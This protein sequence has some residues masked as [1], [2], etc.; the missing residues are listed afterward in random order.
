MIDIVLYILKYILYFVIAF[1]IYF[2]YYHVY[3]PYSQRQYYKKYPNIFFVGDHIPILGDIVFFAKD[4]NEGRCYYD[5]QRAAVERIQDN[6]DFWFEQEGA[7]I[8]LKAISPKAWQEMEQL[9]PAKVDRLPELIGFGKVLRNSFISER[10]T[11]HQMNRRK[12]FVNSL[13][14]NECSKYIPTMVKVAE[15]RMDSF[16]ETTEY[17]LTYEMYIYTFTVFT[18][19]IFG[20]DMLDLATKP[21]KYENKLG[22]IETKNL[23]E[24]FLCILKDHLE[25]MLHPI[26]SFFP[27][28]NKKNLINPFK[29]NEKNLQYHREALKEVISKVKDEKSVYKVLLK[30]ST[31]SEEE[32]FGDVAAILVAGADT[33]SHTLAAC[34]Y[35][36]KK[37]PETLEKLRKELK[38]RGIV[39]D[40]DLSSVLTSEVISE[41]DYLSY[42]I[43][44]ALR[45]DPPARETLLYK[46]YEDVEI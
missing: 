6:H 38:E 4:V 42:V 3:K 40:A 8:N 31:Y 29:R 1:L 30:D 10:S 11:T 24:Q 2:I 28:L 25:G 16:N 32:V 43:K 7:R 13:S 9:I 23:R 36:L 46:V 27:S 45:L 15:E 34:L 33:S 39:R 17:E 19:V 5:H 14:T 37:Y 12:T 26:T 41:I 20:E 35:Y 21:V 22:Q 44:E 18:R